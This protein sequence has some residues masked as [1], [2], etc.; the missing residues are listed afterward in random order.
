[1]LAAKH[2][3]KISLNGKLVLTTTDTT[4]SG[5]GKVG[6]WTRADSVT[7]FDWIVVRTLP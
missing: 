3:F 1:L 7:H 2:D 6:L 5:P 4:F